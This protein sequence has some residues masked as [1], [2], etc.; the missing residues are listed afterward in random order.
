MQ[1]FHFLDILVAELYQ[2][3]LFMQKT[4]NVGLEIIIGY[5]PYIQMWWR[6]PSDYLGYL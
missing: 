3:I 5:S 6:Q 4:W 1:F 2:L